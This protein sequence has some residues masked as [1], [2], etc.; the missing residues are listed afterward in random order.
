MEHAGLAPARSRST[1]DNTTI[2]DGAGDN[3]GHRWPR[4]LRSARRSTNTTSDYDT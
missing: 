2:V 4:A 3:A 1:K